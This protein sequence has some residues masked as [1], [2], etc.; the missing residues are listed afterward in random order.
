M[1]T[2]THMN[3]DNSS[4][5]TIDM[6]DE[7]LDD[8]ADMPAN[9]PFPPGAHLV[10]LKAKRNPKKAG[11]YVIEMTHKQTVELGNPGDNEPKEGDKSA[12]F[13]STKKKDGTVNEFGQGQLKLILKPIGTMLGTSSVNECLEATKDGIDCIVVVGVRKSKE[14]Q[15]DDQQSIIKLELAE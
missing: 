10:S 5:E 6:V 8:L 1:N 14:P 3:N 15:Y 2:N 4:D 13:I 9:Q 7:I 11:S 12:L